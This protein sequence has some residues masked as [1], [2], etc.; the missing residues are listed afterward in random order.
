MLVGL[1]DGAISSTQHSQEP[2]EI[3][4][5]GALQYLET[6]GPKVF[7][8]SDP[9]DSKLLRNLY[10]PALALGLARRK[11]LVFS[12]L[13]WSALRSNLMAQTSPN[14]YFGIVA[15]LP[16][17]LEH[18]DV[19][20]NSGRYPLTG[21]DTDILG[22]LRCFQKEVD[23][24]LCADFFG[25]DLRNVST[26]DLAAFDPTIEEHIMIT[27]S[28]TFDNFHRFERKIT[29]MARVKTSTFC[30]LGLLL[31]HCTVLRLLHRGSKRVQTAVLAED[32]RQGAQD[33][34]DQL[35]RSVYMLSQLGSIAYA[36]Y[37]H[38][39]LQVAQSF[40]EDAGAARKMVWCEACMSATRIRIDRLRAT[41]PPTLCRIGDLADS[42]ASAVR[43]QRA[44]AWKTL[45]SA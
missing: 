23:A 43:C 11:A 29:Q 30:W 22:R 6:L 19:V 26:N 8:L 32:S 40:Y 4:F 25:E 37:T 41:C 3:H 10:G 9:Y 14:D 15:K 28:S 31:S 17:L 16:A 5:W 35:C 45:Y 18:A 24:C 13:E 27:N 21:A 20:L 33:A 1:H 36:E 7:D 42:L 34:A 12:R 39:L 38:L 44:D 2:W